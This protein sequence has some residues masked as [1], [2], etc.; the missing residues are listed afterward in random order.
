MTDRLAGGNLEERIRTL[1]NEGLSFDAIAARLY[2]EHQ[3]EVTGTTIRSW[4]KQ[5]GIEPATKS[6]GQ[7]SKAAS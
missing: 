5:L 4:A 6:T 2:A 1:R 7:R 3:I